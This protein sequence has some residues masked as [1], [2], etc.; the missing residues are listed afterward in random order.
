MAAAVEAVPDVPAAAMRNRILPGR[1]S[2]GCSSFAIE[3]RGF[4]KEGILPG[5]GTYI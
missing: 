3:L 4:R 5:I 1:F 2:E